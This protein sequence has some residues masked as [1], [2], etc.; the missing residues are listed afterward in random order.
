[1]VTDR[2]KHLRV[3]TN[4]PAEMLIGGGEVLFATV[5][6][7]SLGGLQLECDRSSMQRIVPAGHLVSPAAALKVRVRLH[8]PSP[9]QPPV[10]IEAY[11]KIINVR[12]LS[13]QGY[14]VGLQYE[15]VEKDGQ[16]A[17]ERYIATHSSAS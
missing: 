6:S 15:K 4:L 10:G 17:L 3:R 12:R 8:L 14:S 7:V 2:R 11:C 16:H 1:M 5:L 13:Q 9:Q